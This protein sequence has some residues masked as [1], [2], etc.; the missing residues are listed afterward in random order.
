VE[1][2]RGLALNPEKTQLTTFG[3]GGD[4][5]GYAVS[6]RP[7]RRGGQA[8][9]RC[10]TKSKARTRRSHHLDAAVGRQGNRV[11]RGPVRDFAPACS[12][13]LGQFHDLERGIRM[14]IRCRKYKRL[15]TTDNR[16]VKSRHLKRMGVVL[17]RA[18]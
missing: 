17:C 8:E 15:W 10:K 18:V 9:A 6:A 13:C 1:D 7:I 2:D 16:R 14:R 3:Q 11:I 4:F 5:L 12:T